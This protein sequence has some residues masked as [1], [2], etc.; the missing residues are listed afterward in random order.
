MEESLDK[1]IGLINYLL[2]INR[3]AN[4]L[5]ALY[6]QAVKGDPDFKIEEGLLLY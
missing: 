6:K 4:A 5:R 2:T 3:T 1:P